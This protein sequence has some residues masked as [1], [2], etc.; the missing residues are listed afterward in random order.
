MLKIK[1]S[2]KRKILIRCT[3]SLARSMINLQINTNDMLSE[4]IYNMEKVH[5][6]RKEINKELI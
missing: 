1:I 2:W 6:R 4:M 5:A 3:L